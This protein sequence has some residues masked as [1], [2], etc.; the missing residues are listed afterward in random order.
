MCGC[1]PHKRC[2]YHTA[3]DQ[4]EADLEEKAILKALYERKEPNADSV[5]YVMMKNYK[6]EKY[7]EMQRQHRARQ[8]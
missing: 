1:E 2:A 8:G 3:M 4:I 7:W 5:I 6:P